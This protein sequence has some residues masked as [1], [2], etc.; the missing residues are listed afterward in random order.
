MLSQ[1]Q[2]QAV[3][4]ASDLVILRDEQG[5]LLGYVART[6]SQERID[7]AKNRLSSQGPWHTTE[8]VL[9]HL[10]SGQQQ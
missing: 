5:N 10:D 9:S 7:R 4:A 6:I 3:N 8:Q 2:V 1:D